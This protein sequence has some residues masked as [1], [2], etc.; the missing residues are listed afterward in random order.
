MAPDSARPPLFVWNWLPAVAALV[1]GIPAIVVTALVDVG[2]GAALAV[3]MIPALVV[4]V[5]H[6]RRSRLVIV[7]A[8]LVL[9]VPIILGSAVAP[10]PVLAVTVM[11]VLPVLAVWSAPALRR[12]RLSMLLTIMAPPLIGVGLSSDGVAVGLRITGLFLLGGLAAFVVAVVIPE[13]LV[14]DGPGGGPGPRV[15]G[16]Q[17]G[18]LV[19]VVGAITAGIGFASGFDHVGW[20][21]AAALLVMRPDPDLQLWRTAGRFV[22]VVTGGAAAVVLVDHAPAWSLAIVVG[23][24]LAAAAATR[25]SRWYILPTF[26]TFLVIL[27][28]GAATTGTAPGRFGERVGETLLGLAVAAVVGV[29]VPLLRRRL[30]PDSTDVE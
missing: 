28:L 13:R 14:P 24:V 21:C 29:G 9:G 20:A 3:G 1:A 30:H 6:A 23:V 5:P 8:G 22:S 4:G 11:A 10:F 15:P 2:A 12:P 25:G 17:Y 18:L 27:M 19:G 26:T 16:M 7:A